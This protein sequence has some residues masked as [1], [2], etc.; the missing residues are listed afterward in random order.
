LLKA[1]EMM[2]LEK[3]VMKIKAVRQHRNPAWPFLGRG[4]YHDPFLATLG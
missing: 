2:S 1:Q 3:L 4:T